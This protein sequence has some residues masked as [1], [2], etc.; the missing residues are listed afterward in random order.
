MKFLFAMLSTAVL[1]ASACGAL[2]AAFPWRFQEP[3]YAQFEHAKELTRERV[4]ERAPIIA[5][6][7]SRVKAAILPRELGPG[8]VS[9]SF[10]GGS[11]IE[12]FYTLERYLAT[13]PAPERA[14]VGF[15]PVHF[16][17]QFLFWDRTI[18]FGYLDDA[19]VDEVLATADALGDDSL[20]GPWLSRVER[21]MHRVRA[22]HLYL[23]E[24]RAAALRSRAPLNDEVLARA[25]EGRGHLFFGTAERAGGTG[26]EAAHAN[27]DGAP[28]YER[29]LRRLLDR[30][31]EVG[32]EVRYQAMPIN[33]AT[34]AAISPAYRRGYERMLGRVAADYPGVRFDY[35]LPVLPDDCFGDDDHVNARGAAI[36]TAAMRDGEALPLPARPE[37]A[38][39][40]D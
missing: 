25:R 20:G 29:Y 40:R 8:A 10:A 26:Y 34:H 5:L 7:D 6:G 15:A 1:T 14:V 36:V 18:K 16:H 22:L 37:R 31:L 38:A 23:P 13:H 39:G 3:S 11:P 35:L 21:A 4:A 30:L 28:I 24:L 19:Q 2:V 32:V 9:L 27:F 12:L 33:R 17:G